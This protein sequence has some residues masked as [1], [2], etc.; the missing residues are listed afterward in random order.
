MQQHDNVH[1]FDAMTTPNSG[2]ASS[3]MLRGVAKAPARQPTC[4][5]RL[6]PK[7]ITTKVV[8]PNVLSKNK[9]EEKGGGWL[10]NC[11]SVLLSHK[12]GKGGVGGYST[13]VLF[14]QVI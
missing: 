11:C 6:L 9:T 2:A 8:I 3:A 4:L 10:L 1:T 7:K 14:Y 5:M 12:T 13:L